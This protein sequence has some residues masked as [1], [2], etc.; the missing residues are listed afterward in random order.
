[1]LS[2]D[3]GV[4]PKNSEMGMCCWMRLQFH[5]WLTIVGLLFQESLECRDLADFNFEGS[6]GK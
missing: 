1:M 5:D 6:D 2:G 4:L 3:K